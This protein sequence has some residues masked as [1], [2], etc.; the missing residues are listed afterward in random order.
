MV[1]CYKGMNKLAEAQM[2]PNTQ[3][4]EQHAVSGNRGKKLRE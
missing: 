2:A 1:L 3:S 4:P